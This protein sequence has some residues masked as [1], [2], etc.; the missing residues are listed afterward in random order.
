MNTTTRLQPGF[1]ELSDA[2]T[3]LAYLKCGDLTL[4][5]CKEDLSLSNP[6]GTVE[7]L[8]F[9]GKKAGFKIIYCRKS[10]TLKLTD[11]FIEPLMD[12]IAWSFRTYMLAWKSQF[13]R[14]VWWVAN[15]VENT[16]VGSD[17]PFA[18]RIVDVC[19]LVKEQ[20]TQDCTTVCGKPYMGKRQ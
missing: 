4:K 19:L 13:Q 18:S 11:K 10:S 17:F 14:V 1:H 16:L 2:N 3:L 5:Y 20:I 8:R 6:L 9:I 12:Q 15:R 7:L